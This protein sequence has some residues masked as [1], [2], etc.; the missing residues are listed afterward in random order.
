MVHRSDYVVSN[1]KTISNNKSEGI[2]KEMSVVL[3]DHVA[4]V[5]KL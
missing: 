1:D 4:V 3:I 5:V 2:W